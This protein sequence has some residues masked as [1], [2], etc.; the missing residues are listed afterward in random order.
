MFTFLRKIRRRLIAEHRLR[1]YL[2]YAIGEIVL[3]VVGILIALQINL[4]NEGRKR[5]SS[6]AEVLVSLQNE[7][8]D[9][10][11]RLERIRHINDSLRTHAAE[12]LEDLRNGSDVFS[13]REIK[14][15]LDYHYST[16]DAP[17]LTGLI[18]ANSSILVKRKDLI[19]HLRALK[20]AYERI[21]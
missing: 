3:V 17:V 18:A 21:E 14:S 19:P 13:V 7:I 2:L 16:V 15:A 11:S 5:I 12:V 1:D 10:M 6:E 9:N 4:W 20:V 8:I